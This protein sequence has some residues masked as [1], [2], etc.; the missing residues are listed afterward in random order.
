MLSSTR[1]TRRGAAVSALIVL[2]DR[3]L[4]AHREVS[5]W[6][7]FACFKRLV[8]RTFRIRARLCLADHVTRS[9]GQSTDAISIV[10][11]RYGLGSRSP[12]QEKLNCSRSRMPQGM[13]QPGEPAW[14][15]PAAMGMLLL[16]A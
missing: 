10:P 6:Y 12:P 14:P 11:T 3:K 2:T 4:G 13:L 7:R 8:C 16:F 9:Q 15:L 5:T 1:R